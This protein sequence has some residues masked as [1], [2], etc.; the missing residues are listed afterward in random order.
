MGSSA[1][2][3]LHLTLNGK[4]ALTVARRAKDIE[5]T[6][7]LISPGTVAEIRKGGDDPPLLHWCRNHFK[8]EAC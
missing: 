6:P 3:I 2:E 5:E 1:G 4:A 8:G 7:R